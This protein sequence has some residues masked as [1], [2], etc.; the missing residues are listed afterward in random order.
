MF[1]GLVLVGHSVRR[2]CKLMAWELCL[3]E[4]TPLLAYPSSVGCVVRDIH[5]LLA[6]F[7]IGIAISP[8]PRFAHPARLSRCVVYSGHFWRR[9]MVR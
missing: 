6:R 4:C 2:A 7:P 1:A 3:V 9:K 5:F 8:P